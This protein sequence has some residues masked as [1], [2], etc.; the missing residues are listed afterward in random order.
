MRARKTSLVVA[1]VLCAIPACKNM[2]NGPPFVSRGC[3]TTATGPTACTNVLPEN[4]KSDLEKTAKRIDNQNLLP[5]ARNPIKQTRKTDSDCRRDRFRNDKKLVINYDVP[6][7]MSRFPID[8]TAGRDLVVAVFTSDGNTDCREAKYGIL[9][10]KGGAKQGIVYF[11]TVQTDRVDPVVTR[12]DRRIGNWTAWAIYK[13]DNDYVLDDLREGAYV[14]CGQKHDTTFKN[15]AFTGCETAHLPPTQ[16]QVGLLD[17]YFTIRSANASVVRG[18]SAVFDPLSE[19]VDPAW[20][21]CGALGC[22]ASY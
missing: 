12:Y 17:R 14:Q 16:R 20:G 5:L 2:W 1:I 3:S 4:W 9:D 13:K 21:R 6:L 22:C 19:E 11:I 8:G 15:L 10:A 18:S 7:D